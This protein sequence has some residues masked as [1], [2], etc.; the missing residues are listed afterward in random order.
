MA[1]YMEGCF[2]CGAHLVYAETMELYR[3]FRCN[4]E[5]A[6][7]VICEKGHY[8]CD[9][10]HAEEGIFSITQ[11]VSKTSSR[12]PVFI[13]T[14][15]MKVPYI[16]M[17]GPEHHY[18]VAASLLAAYRNAGGEIDLEKALGV[19]RERAKSV[20][21]GIC[22]M[23]GSCGAAIATGIFVSVITGSTPLSTVEWSLANQM[24]SKSL[25][26]ISSHGGPR[27]CKRNTYLAISEAVKYAKNSFAVTMELPEKIQC[28]FFHRNKECRQ[29]KCIYF[30][31]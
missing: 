29:N 7:N 11:F 6:V 18:L 24:T 16:N 17:H 9:A 8:I 13:A 2:I 23:W 5:Y 15:L 22:G 14:E 31:R 3:C 20:P 27:C 30:G 25:A 26:T 21:G 28:Q 4:E 12:D 10:C 1:F 19:I